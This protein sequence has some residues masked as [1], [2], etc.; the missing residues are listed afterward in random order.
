[1]SKLLFPIIEENKN[2][3]IT[4][5]GETSHFFAVISPDLEQLLPHKEKE[6]LSD[7]STGLGALNEANYYK[8]YRL[9]GMSY[10]E[11]NA[12]G[13]FPFLG[14]NFVP[15]HHPLEIFFGNSE[16][17]SDIGIY[18]DYI[19]F[20][21]QYMRIL[22]ASEFAG[23]MTPHDL[24]PKNCDYLLSIKKLAPKKAMGKLERIR[25]GHL[26][27]LF[28]G[29]RDIASEGTYQQAEEL[30][31]DLIHQRESLFEMELFFMPKAHALDDLCTQTLSLQA[32]LAA[33]GVKAF[34]EGQ[35]LIHLKSG[36]AHFFNELIPGVPPKL[37]LRKHFNKTSHLRHLLPLGS[38]HLMT[39][40]VLF[41]DQGE[42]E[43]FFNPFDQ[44]I[45]NRNM[46]VTG[47]TGSGK[48][49]FVNKLVHHLVHKHPT[50][51]LDKG[52][53]FKK[54][55]LYHNGAILAGKFNPMQFR[56]ALY[57]RE[58]ILSV[59]DKERFSKLDQA[60]LLKQIKRALAHAQTFWELVEFLAKD[61]AGIN[62][63]FEEI[64][65]FIG[66]D[67]IG[68]KKILY[69]DIDNYPKEATAPLIIFL[70]Q[71]FKHIEGKEKILIFD[72]CWSFLKG[73][74]SYIGECFRTFRKTGAFPV[75][76]SQGIDDFSNIDGEIGEAITNN[77]YFKVY[78][79]QRIKVE[80]EFAHN[81]L[82]HFDLK[83]IES[84]D[85]AKSIFSDCYLK[86]SDN[87]FQKIIR[88]Y[89][90]PL[91]LELFH[92][93]A[94]EDDKL[95]QFIQDFGKYFAS[96]AKAIE[97]YIQLRHGDISS[98]IHQEKT[99]ETI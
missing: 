37:A 79:P 53:S 95:F 83:R 58:I 49:V 97:S 6:F 91:E 52:G 29:K 25:T 24:I 27:S 67:I 32:D 20:N 74:A 73:H 55:A 87:K 80:N 78:F 46:L 96:N 65:D 50:V 12:N 8:F 38:S 84:L 17:I 47:S 33:R 66:G 82:T 40:G 70:L 10:L 69:I 92:T 9:G 19:A 56:D 35:S 3:L 63:Y 44:S 93:E 59:V 23:E 26:S 41:H 22:S 72:E 60:K 94:G 99:H 76:I 1:M 42:G 61:F 86:S 57:L 64:A 48:S 88:N 51:I 36:L 71:Y 39:E 14:I 54:L 98:I 43:I 90:T 81:E 4:V 45:K 11:T 7:L 21:G 28:K 13:P 34:I 30:L 31:H 18:D 77:S 16:I 2:K 62:L 5:N 15:Q 89:L 68:N 85:F 75:A